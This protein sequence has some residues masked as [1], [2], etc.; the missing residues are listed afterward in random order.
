VVW[1]FLSYLFIHRSFMHI[2]IASALILAMG[3]LISEVFS[4]FAVLVLFVA[5]G[6]TAALVFGLFSTDGGF[7]LVGAYPVFYGFIGTYTWIR[8]SEL[9]AQGQN[10]LPA[11]API[12]AFF[13]LRT[14]LML[15]AGVPNDWMADL[16]GLVVGFLLAYILAPDG[17]DRIKGWVRAIRER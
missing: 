16:T 11:F 3:K 9:L 10:I 7:P 1:P 12:G 15:Y 2:L 14:G 4:G 6:L 8:I 13:I 5:C 17:K